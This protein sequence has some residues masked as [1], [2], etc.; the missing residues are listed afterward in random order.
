MTCSYCISFSTPR[1]LILALLP[2]TLQRAL[3][4]HLLPLPSTTHLSFPDLSTSF[5][6]LYIPSPSVQPVAPSAH[7]HTCPAGTVAQLIPASHASAA[8]HG[9]S[10][11]KIHC[12]REPF[13]HNLAVSACV[14]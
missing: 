11:K 5:L 12:E 13:Y 10:T 2:P 6:L 9:E 1:I 7:R 3:L 14:R 4:S 8:V